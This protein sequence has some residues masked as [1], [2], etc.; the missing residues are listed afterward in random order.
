MLLFL[1]LYLKKV[2]QL[3]LL[4]CSCSSRTFLNQFKKSNYLCVP[5]LVKINKYYSNCSC[6]CSYSAAAAGLQ[7][8]LQGCICSSSILL[9]QFRT[10]NEPCVCSLLIMNALFSKL[11]NLLLLPALYSQ[12]VLQLQQLQQQYKFFWD[13]DLDPYT[14]QG[15]VS[16]FQKKISS[17]LVV[18]TE[19]L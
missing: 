9:D 5:D 18:I 14:K 13:H 2:L 17:G 11:F 8:Q 4:Y 3:L 7:L 15:K 10:S 6:R 16:D 19:K 1:D 12:K